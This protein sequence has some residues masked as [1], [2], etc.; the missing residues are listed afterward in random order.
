MDA[1]WGPAWTQETAMN[2]HEDKQP[3]SDARP[4]DIPLRKP[5]IAP[6][7]RFLGSLGSFTESGGSAAR[8]IHSEK[9]SRF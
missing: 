9:K 3:L 5:Y 8:E 6:M 1:F 2:E 7:L 4:S